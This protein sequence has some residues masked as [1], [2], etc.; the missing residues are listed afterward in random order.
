M[1][2]GKLN[3]GILIET[4]YCCGILRKFEKFWSGKGMDFYWRCFTGIA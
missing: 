4:C 3:S 2:K 1:R